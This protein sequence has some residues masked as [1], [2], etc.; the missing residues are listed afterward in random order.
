MMMMMMVMYKSKVNGG[1]NPNRKIGLMICKWGILQGRPDDLMTNPCYA[2]YVVEDVGS[3]ETC[4]Y[5]Y[6]Y[7]YIRIY[8]YT[9]I[10]ICVYLRLH[11]Y[12]CTY[13][14][15]HTYICTYIYIHIYVYT[16]KYIYIYIYIHTY[17]QCF[18]RF[19]FR[20]KKA[21]CQH[22][23]EYPGDFSDFRRFFPHGVTTFQQKR[24]KRGKQK[25]WGCS[26]VTHF[27][28]FAMKNRGQG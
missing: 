15:L 19:F 6:I 3:A 12:I 26:K 4:I 14:Y 25:E 27:I 8:V 22:M 21:R 10:R 28:P 2:C 18:L 11:T 5:L 9:Y 23:L 24:F 20:H 7:T 16:Y 17:I 13:T 1:R